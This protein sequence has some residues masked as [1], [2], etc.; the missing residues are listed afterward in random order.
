MTG[1]TK[2]LLLAGTSEATALA[3]LLSEGD[4][5]EVVASFAGR[6]RSL[7]TL[8][9][10]THV[11]GFGGVSGLVRH[12]RQGGYQCVV[13]AT[14][15][16]AARMPTNAARAAEEVGIPRLRLM[17]PSWQA[18]PGDYWH[19][20]PTLESAAGML[21]ARPPRRGFLAIGRT[22]LAAFSGLPGKQFV[23][24]SIEPPP[25]GVLRGATIILDRPPFT[26]ASERRLLAEY[27]IDI[28][29]TKD[30]GGSA[31]ASK[32]IAARER[33][34]PV[35]VVNRPLPPAGALTDRVADAAAWVRSP[36]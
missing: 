26:L 16:F 28:L 5:V 13:D 8:P 14:H 35:V 31:T 17:R 29:V 18:E 6:I 19:R 7:S 3:T 30:S 24:R 20:V 11:G 21:R 2:V 33:G 9:C 12:L 36:S 1:R 4:D 25:R 10:A 15:P 22:S 23:V 27:G 32:L 34:I